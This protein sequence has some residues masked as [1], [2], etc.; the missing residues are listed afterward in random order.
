MTNNVQNSNNHRHRRSCTGRR[1]RFW[2][3]EQA[4]PSPKILRNTVGFNRR[5][6][7]YSQKVIGIGSN[8]SA[9][10]KKWRILY[11]CKYPTMIFYNSKIE[12][13]KQE[14]IFVCV[15]LYEKSPAHGIRSTAAHANYVY[16]T[17]TER[18]KQTL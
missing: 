6:R 7:K 5:V 17:K 4:T 13:G 8:S 1:R 14:R 11:E 18:K 2:F 9:Q 12:K 3:S 10:K 15:C 16:T